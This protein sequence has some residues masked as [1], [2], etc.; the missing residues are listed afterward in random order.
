MKMTLIKT[1]GIMTL[2]LLLADLAAAFVML[3]TP[4]P[5]KP[6]TEPE[7][8]HIRPTADARPAPSIAR[9]AYSPPPLPSVAE[10]VRPKVSD[11][12]AASVAASVPQETTIDAPP[13]RP[14]HGWLT[15]KPM[16]THAGQ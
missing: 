12:T 6:E 16:I 7:I 4:A 13:R 15:L 5:G 1:V 9:V 2:V 3:I 8:R 14:P 10:A 11:E